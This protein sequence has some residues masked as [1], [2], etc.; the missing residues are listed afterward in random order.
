M[1]PI[2]LGGIGTSDCNEIEKVK[3]WLVIIILY[4]VIIATERKYKDLLYSGIVVKYLSFAEWKR[5]YILEVFLY[6]FF[7]S[8]ISYICVCNKVDILIG[9]IA[10]ALISFNFAVKAI[11]IFF[12]SGKRNFGFI[13][14]IFFVLEILCVQFGEFF[15][16]FLFEWSM[17]NRSNLINDEG[18]SVSGVMLCEVILLFISCKLNLSNLR[19]RYF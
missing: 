19:E 8:L 13:I 12:I 11:L 1:L 7:T 4:I 14:C 16:I 10:V 9:F 18:F 2:N 15:D 3:W 6:V 5:K 17:V